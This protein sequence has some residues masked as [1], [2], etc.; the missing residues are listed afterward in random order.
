MAALAGHFLSFYT[1]GR[2]SAGSLATRR[3]VLATSLPVLAGRLPTLAG[4]LPAG[5]AGASRVVLCF[6][7]ASDSPTDLLWLHLDPQGQRPPV[8]RSVGIQ[9]WVSCQPDSGRYETNLEL[10]FCVQDTATPKKA[11]QLDWNDLTNRCAVARRGRHSPGHR[12]LLC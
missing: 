3:P 2:G 11:W 7:V 8:Q 4:H 9:S 1:L 12:R 10:V 5:P 6:T